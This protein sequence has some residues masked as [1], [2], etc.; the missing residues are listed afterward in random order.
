MNLNTHQVLNLQTC[1]FISLYVDMYHYISENVFHHLTYKVFHHL[2]QD[3]YVQYV[4]GKV[5]TVSVYTG[6]YSISFLKKISAIIQVYTDRLKFSQVF[7]SFLS[8]KSSFR[9]HK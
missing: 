1:N 4:M 7:L 8:K 5:Y 3:L 2:Y 9:I 6:L